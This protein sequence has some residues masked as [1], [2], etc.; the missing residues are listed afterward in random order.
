MAHL[1]LED[2]EGGLMRRIQA[3]ALGVI[4]SMA[5]ANGALGHI[6]VHGHRGARALR[7]E[8]TIPAFEYA[9]SIGVDV[10]EMDLAVTKDRVLVLSH[11]PRLNPEI[12]EEASGKKLKEP[13]PLIFS[14]TLVEVKKYVCGSRRDPRFPRQVLKP[15]TRIPTL[16]EVFD[17]VKKSSHPAAKT[18]RFNIETK[19]DPKKPDDTANPREFAFLL[20]EELKKSGM[21]DRAIIQSFDDRTLVELRKLDPKAQIAVLSEDPNED[22][23][24]RLK[25]TQ[26][27]IF[28]PYWEFLSPALVEKVRSLDVK[29]VPWTANG[30]KAWKKLSDMQVD[31]I[32]SDDPEALIKF[33]KKDQATRAR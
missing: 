22:F 11:D 9:L 33:L 14:M 10:L 20:V 17:H 19:I 7:P 21:K 3:W 5:F 15:G 30:P 31:G 4:L 6:E 26:A 2:G 12:C 16:A 25:A 23:V 13:G 28:S 24:G 1:Q 27:D 8:N 18:V 29:I 32:I